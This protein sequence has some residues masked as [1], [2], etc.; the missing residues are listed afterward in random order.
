MQ[1]WI[2][3][4]E[5]CC[6]ENRL[7]RVL[8]RRNRSPLSGKASEFYVVST[9]DWVNVVALTRD[10]RL[11]MVR[12]FRHGTKR[13]TLE[14]PGGAVD[15]GEDALAAAKRELREETGYA[16]DRWIR[17][18]L[19]EPNPAI[20]D[21]RCISFLAF[22][23]EGVGPLEPDEN[24]EITVVTLPWEEVKAKVL[25]GEIRHAIVLTA[26]YL[27]ENWKTLHG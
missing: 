11:V 6:Y 24:E 23:A 17:L 19:V 27:F 1:P 10:Q 22:D 21:N 15:E 4:N 18:G 2:Q 3:E 14:I 7:F 12:Q 5:T 8:Q 26:F 16:S 20:Q 9:H 13:V 25:S